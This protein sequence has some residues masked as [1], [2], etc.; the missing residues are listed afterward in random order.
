MLLSGGCPMEPP[1]AGKEVDSTSAGR[2]EA[3]TPSHGPGGT[4][5][6][7]RGGPFDKQIGVLF[8]AASA[9]EITFISDKIVTAISSA[10]GEGVVDVTLVNAD[11]R[12]VL[13]DAF[14]Y[15]DGSNPD[16][17]M[18][19]DGT[20]SD[21]DGLSDIEETT[22]WEVWIDSFAQASFG[23]D[24]YY[25]I[26][27]YSVESDP[28]DPDSD[29]DGLSDEVEMLIKSNPRKYDSDDDGLWDGEEWN[30][31]LTSPTSVDTDGDARGR[32]DPGDQ[33]G[34]FELASTSVSAD[35]I[36]ELRACDSR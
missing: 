3:V 11:G 14:R 23:A 24:T 13:P 32:S 22:G 35:A 10:D 21:G 4:V 16:A 9:T 2:I 6:T 5:V 27:H 31:W 1:P 15:T 12:V 29:D 33:A 25:N 17:A 18:R 20:D 26:F 30:Q 34:P 19:D 7:L 28:N 36:K 8:G